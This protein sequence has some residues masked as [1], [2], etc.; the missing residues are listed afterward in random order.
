MPARL[1]LVSLAVL[2]ISGCGVPGDADE[3]VDGNL[4]SNR[5]CG[6][7]LATTEAMT[8]DPVEPAE[9]ER[10]A[11]RF[12]DDQRTLAK[13]RDPQLADVAGRLAQSLRRQRWAA[14]VSAMNETTDQTCLEPAG[15]RWE[16]D[17]KLLEL[18]V[19]DDW[20]PAVAEAWALP[21]RGRVG[22]A[23]RSGEAMTHGPSPLGEDYR[24][25][26]PTAYFAISRSLAKELRVDG[27]RTA[28]ALDRLR[29]WMDA[30]P[31]PAGCRLTGTAPFAKGVIWGFMRRSDG[32]GGFGAALIEIYGIALHRRPEVAVVVLRLTGR[33]TSSIAMF[34][35]VVDTFHVIH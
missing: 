11:G 25:V 12:A 10:L 17:E 7:V 9:I 24:W 3:L 27:G 21:G 35:R 32:C 4:P 14:V 34:R 23:I 20:S 33:R 18:Q 26:F 19:P 22:T 1:V 5:F 13:V 16:T 30:T 31:L 28:V 2:A 6:D 15:Y 8:A 29:H